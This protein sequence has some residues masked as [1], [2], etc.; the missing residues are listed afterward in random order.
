MKPEEKHT[1][2]ER[3]QNRISNYNVFTWAFD[4]STRHLTQKIAKISE[5]KVYHKAISSQIVTDYRKRPE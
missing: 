1:R 5:R 4:F 2:L 3:M